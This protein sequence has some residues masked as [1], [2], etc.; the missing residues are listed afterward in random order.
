[1]I[2]GDEIVHV[3]FSLSEF[4]LVHTLTSVPMEEGLSSEHSS[5]LFTD[6]LE[7]L[8]DG[9]WVSEESDGHLETLGWDI[10]NWWLNVVGDPLNEVRWV[11]VLNVQ[12]LFIDFFGWHSTSEESWGGEISTV[13]WVRSAHHVLSIEHLLGELGDGKG[14]VLL[15]TSWGKRGETSHEE[16]ESGEWNQVDS[17]LSE[18]RVELTWES[19]AAGNTWDTS[20]DQVIKIT[21][22]GGGELEGSEADIIESFVINAHNLISIFD[23][24]M[25]W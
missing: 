2:L 5:E 1:L 19:E 24:L 8:L 9:S 17:E 6:S 15:R 10:A 11:L 3:G 4:H 14:S 23:K 20:R 21:I 22:G 18:I 16:M 25:D 12:H 7:H 13:S